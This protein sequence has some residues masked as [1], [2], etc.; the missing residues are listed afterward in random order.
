MAWLFCEYHAKEQMQWMI[1][2]KLQPMLILA[3]EMFCDQC[4]VNKRK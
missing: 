1:E 2:Q 4:R 3:P